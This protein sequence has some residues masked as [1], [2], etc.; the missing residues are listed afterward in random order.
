MA[1]WFIWQRFVNLWNSSPGGPMP[2]TRGHCW[3]YTPT[4][5]TNFWF[6]WLWIDT[7]NRERTY[8]CLKPDGDVRP[9]HIWLCWW[10]RFKINMIKISLPSRKVVQG[11]SHC[12]ARR[13]PP[14]HKSTGTSHFSC[15]TLVWEKQ[16]NK[17][18]L[19]WSDPIPANRTHNVVIMFNQ[20]LRSWSDIITTSA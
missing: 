7:E 12:R 20:R 3:I 18:N 17:Q 5:L 4:N 14:A 6:F 11:R 2:S 1:G 10:T 8:T 19:M 13:N 9:P 15:Q 16:E